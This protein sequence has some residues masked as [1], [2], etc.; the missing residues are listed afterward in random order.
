LSWI[1]L[2]ASPTRA[3]ARGTGREVCRLRLGKPPFQISVRTSTKITANLAE[4]GA[5]L[6]QN[7]PH[8]LQNEIALAP[9]ARHFFEG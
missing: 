1:P 6:P 5:E 8:S 4:V 7:A 9:A 2:H 3:C